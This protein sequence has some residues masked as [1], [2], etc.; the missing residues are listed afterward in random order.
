[1]GI[2]SA[3]L[4]VALIVSEAPTLSAQDQA[5]GP[6]LAGLIVDTLGTP[7][8]FAE[9]SVIGS[10]SRT[11]ADEGGRFRLAAVT[12]SQLKFAVRR[13]GYRPVYFDL[14]IPRGAVVEVRIRMTPSVSVLANVEIDGISEP[15]RKVGFYDRMKSGYGYFI[16][17]ARIA[18]MRPMRAS[19]ALLNIPHV[20]VDR[21]GSR[22]RLVGANYTCEYALVVDRVMVGQPGSRIRTSSPD[23]A[24]SGTDLYAIEVYPANRG[25]PAQFLGLSHEAGCGTV[26]IWTKGILLR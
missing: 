25:V 14:A 18:A 7:V 2:R 21:R 17:P 19:D 12:S 10:A 3:V 22:T 5:G 23:D 15:L 11:T 26:I 16:S 6:I 4:V 20:V 13:I 24:V 1:M 8:A 9:V